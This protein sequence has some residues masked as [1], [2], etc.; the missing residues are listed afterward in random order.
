MPLHVFRH[1]LASLPPS[2]NC[3]PFPLK[4][5]ALCKLLH[6]RRA[7]FV[8]KHLIGSLQGGFWGK[9]AAPTTASLPNSSK[10]PRDAAPSASTWLGA[11][12]L[13]VRLPPAGLLALLFRQPEVAS[14]TAVFFQHFQ[15]ADVNILV[16]HRTQRGCPLAERSWKRREFRFYTESKKRGRESPGRAGAPSR[17][18]ATLAS[19]SRPRQ[20]RLGNPGV[21]E[22]PPTP[23]PTPQNGSHRPPVGEPG[24]PGPC[25]T[26]RA[27]GPPAPEAAQG[28]AQQGRR[29]GARRPQWKAPVTIATGAAPRR[30]WLGRPPAA[31]ATGLSRAGPD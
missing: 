30:A 23:I 11:G 6:W 7:N 17:A 8:P 3:L 26:G 24:L 10:T 15:V 1:V 2:K 19:P 31:I 5:F 28:R 16:G 29:H 14:E 27:E 20:G 4:T 13:P 9:P 12:V 22:L 21:R 18:G 25:L